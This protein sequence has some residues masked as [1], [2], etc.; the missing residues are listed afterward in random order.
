[1]TPVTLRNVVLTVTTFTVLGCSSVSMLPKGFPRTLNSY[2]VQQPNDGL[3]FT[4]YTYDLNWDFEEDMTVW[5]LV[6]KYDP[7]TNTRY[8]SKRPY[9]VQYLRMRYIVYRELY[10]YNCDGKV[11]A[12]GYLLEDGTWRIEEVN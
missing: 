2:T 9:K 3:T 8:E 12:V 10:D 11:D 6:T 1:M 5:Y 4:V 7:S